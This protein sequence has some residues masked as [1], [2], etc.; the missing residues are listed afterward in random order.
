[1]VQKEVFLR[2][3]GR[4]FLVGAILAFPVPAHAQEAVLTGTLTDCAPIA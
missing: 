2:R 3:L 1:M 4:L